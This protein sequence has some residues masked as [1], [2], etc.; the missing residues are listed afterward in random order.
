MAV[1]FHH[2]NRMNRV[3]ENKV[4]TDGIRATIWLLNCFYWTQKTS[5]MPTYT[6]TGSEF[7]GEQ[8]AEMLSAPQRASEHQTTDPSGLV[9]PAA[10]AF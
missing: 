7:L 8:R 6:R 9:R 10:A 4:K 3:I 2:P 5:N 1:Y